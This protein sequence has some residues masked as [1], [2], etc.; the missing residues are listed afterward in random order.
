MEGATTLNGTPLGAYGL[1]CNVFFWETETN[2]HCMG[3]RRKISG[4]VD[5]DKT[6]S[7]KMIIFG[8]PKA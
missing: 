4:G 2:V 3:A 8:E 5:Q 7:T 1:S 6:S